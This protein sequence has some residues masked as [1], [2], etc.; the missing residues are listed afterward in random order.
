MKKISLV[1][2]LILTAGRLVAVELKTANSCRLAALHPAAFMTPQ[3]DAAKKA[4]QWKSREEYDAFQAFVQEKDLK[5]RVGL[6]DAFLAKF[7]DSDFK[8]NVHLVAMQTYQQLNDSQGA[9]QAARQVLQSNPGNI[10]ALYLLSYTFQ[11]NFK[12]DDPDLASKLSRAA[13]DA[14]QGLEALQ[15]VQ[16]PANVSD[17][18]FEDYVTAR[19]MLFNNTVGFVALQQKDYAEAVTYLKPAAEESPEDPLVFFR[20]GLA[21]LYMEPADYDNS[22]WFLARAA[23]LAG[24]KGDANQVEIR[25]FLTR[26]YVTRYRSEAGLEE[27][28]NQAAVSVLPPDGFHVPEAPKP[29]ELAT[30]S[31]EVFLTLAHP[32]RGGGETAQKSWD[33]AKGTRLTMA[34]RVDSWERARQPGSYR[35]HVDLVSEES[36]QERGV[37]DLVL[38]VGGQSR[39]K[40]LARGDAIRFEGELSGYEVTPQFVFTMENGKVNP[41]DLPAFAPGQSPDKKPAT[42][43]RRIQKKD[44]N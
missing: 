2:A 20:L 19:R 43:R 41:E 27:I 11:Y 9:T 15:K 22:V 40:N 44:Q 8:E 33:Q 35:V 34:G 17:T 12:P 13:S 16:K 25:K 42:R 24:A 1:L 3:A 38:L 36:R 6:L 32:L 28:V 31:E 23:S 37:F 10:D 30:P 18:Q 26:A 5:K 21:Y 4:P 29:P 39:V 14:R 7:T